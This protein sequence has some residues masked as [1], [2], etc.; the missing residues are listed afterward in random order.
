MRLRLIILFL[1]A[2][3]NA[4]QAQQ[5]FIAGLV[6]NSR[7]SEPVKM[8]SVK[9]DDGKAAIGDTNGYF[10]ITVLPGKRLL[11]L[12]SVGYITTE[13]VVRLAEDDQ[14]TVII[15][16]EP[17]VSELSRTVI[18]ASKHEKEVSREAVSINIIKPS[19][20]RN[21]NANTLSD[22]MNRVPG[23]SVVEGQALIRGGVG[24]SYNV[25]SR[26][27]VL[28]DDM[29]MMGGDVGDVQWD[30]MPIEAAEQIEV[31]KG[32][33]SVLYGNSASSG[34]IALQTGWPTNKPQTYIQTYQGIFDNPKRKSTIWWER[35]S[36]P[37]T[38]GAF[39]VHK[40]KFGQF[41]LV[42]STNLNAERSY[43][44]Q[45]D[46]YR[47]RTYFKTRYRS[48]K[49][50]GLA[51]GVNGTFMLKKGGRFFLWED[52][53]SNILRP[54]AGSTG[55]D[56]YRIWSLDPHLT[57][58]HGNK[59]TLSLKM[60]HYNITR[61]VDTVAFPGQNDAVAN[62]QAYDVNFNRRWFKGF[63]S[64]S[65]V[66]INRVWA[67]GNVYPGNQ[68]AYS[69]A[70]F[71]QL[72][73]QRGRWNTS[74]GLRYEFNAQGPIEETQR[75]LFRAG[76]N[77]QASKNTFLRASYGEGFRFAT[78]AERLVQDRVASLEIL[79]NPALQSE[80]GWYTEIGIKRGFKIG[81][82]NGALD[83][84][85][86]WQEYQNLIQ[87][88][89][90]QWVRDSFYIDYSVMPPQFYSFP[91]KIGFKATNFPNTL[92]AGMEFAIDGEGSIGEFY[93]STLCGYT[94]TFPVDLDSASNLKS[95]GPY[96]RAFFN[97]LDGLSAEER[98]SILTYRNRHLVKAD[99]EVRY[100]KLSIGYNSQYY[101]V[102]EKIDAPLYTLIPGIG[103][104]LNNVGAGDW[105]HNIRTSYQ[106]SQQITIALLV[107]NI[108]NREFGTRPARLDPP[109]S[110]NL[111]VRIS[112]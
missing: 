41:D 56:Y 47:V 2:I 33:S 87:F 102:Y 110:I 105:I 92:T 58:T 101:S 64:I 111:Q 89:F 112:L 100:K 76:L 97:G 91:G 60:R 25:G 49:I 94:Y 22:V 68:S 3:S 44:E 32:P 7:T 83:A 98:T 10:K 6:K 53:D 90:K 55:Q 85:F 73:Y 34:T 19:L 104:F 21:T 51:T 93:I 29:P 107:N 70:G 27:M 61:F 82:F 43:I 99:I 39:L 106:A 109:R 17:F 18:T 16:M 23:V 40:Q 88:Q 50:P 96:M 79:P 80:R 65:G 69:A 11:K 52:A 26:V 81:N 103:N 37:F 71:T 57:Y 1:F 77:Y 35:T 62:L 28:L 12:N 38:T 24:W 13:Q 63:N 20:I 8:V 5:A 75:P 31:I 108:A 15:Y 66:Y 48:Q 4:L 14:I 74:T 72:E 36:Q 54:F 78:I 30:L 95:F 42:L 86:F 9:C 59:Y 46:Q 67:T 45:N 84:C